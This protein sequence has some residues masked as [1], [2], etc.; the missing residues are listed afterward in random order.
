MVAGNIT[1]NTYTSYLRFTNDNALSLTAP[2]VGRYNL[3]KTNFIKFELNVQ[4]LKIILFL[5]C[6]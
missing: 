5:G 6:H 4:I 2:I 3:Y 1:N